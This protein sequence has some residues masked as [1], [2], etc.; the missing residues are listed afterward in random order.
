ME[1]V[2]GQDGAAFDA[3]CLRFRPLIY[4]TVYRIINNPQDAEDITQDVLL[5]IWK[6]AGSWDASKGKLSTWIASIARN[7]SID[8]IRNKNRRAVL[9]TG[10]ENTLACL[11]KTARQR[12]S[13]P[14][15]IRR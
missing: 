2:S 8:V 5:S 7:R 1:G 9:R 3:L 15:P 13:V 14:Q 4:A 12:R 11:L 10:A 6:K